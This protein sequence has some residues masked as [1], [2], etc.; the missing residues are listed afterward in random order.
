MWVWS[1][2]GRGEGVDIAC[3]REVKI[4][5]KVLV[6]GFPE[7][8]VCFMVAAVKHKGKKL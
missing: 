6:V 8:Y 7:G 4:W 3:V 1:L 5:A 2:C